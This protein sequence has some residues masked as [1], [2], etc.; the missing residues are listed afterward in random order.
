MIAVN[1]IY[2]RPDTSALQKITC[3][4]IKN[5]PKYHGYF[6]LM[7]V[8]KKKTA[9]SYSKTRYSHYEKDQ[10]RRIL[11]ETNIVICSECNTPKRSHHACA[12]CGK[13]RGRQVIV[14]KTTADDTTRIQA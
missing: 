1:R 7:A 14:Q 12:E 13:Y 11:N 10:Q 9:K 4:R 6:L 5:P 2:E 8:P 3:A